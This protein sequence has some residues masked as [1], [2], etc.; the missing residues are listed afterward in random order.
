MENII[1]IECIKGIELEDHK[2]FLEKWSIDEFV[3]YCILQINYLSFPNSL[4]FDPSIRN[5]KFL[6]S[7]TRG[8]F[9]NSAENWK[10][11]E[12]YFNYHKPIMYGTYDTSITK[13]I[14][15]EDALNEKIDNDNS[16]MIPKLHEFIYLYGK[17]RV[18]K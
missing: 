18:N 7:K 16:D 12:D 1:T 2:L 9:Y 13:S 10:K 14:T 11:I 8:L 4:D 3:K 6:F 15:I 5:T 17:E